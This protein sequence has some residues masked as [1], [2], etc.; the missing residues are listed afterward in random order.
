MKLRLGLVA[1]LLA[2]MPAVF[3]V[4]QE[5][6]RG[7]QKRR[8]D[9]VTSGYRKTWA[10]IV[11]VDYEGRQEDVKQDPAD[12]A[13]LPALRNAVNDATA[14]ADV[15]TTLYNYSREDGELQLLVEEEA[16]KSAIE[17]A[18]GRLC[19]PNQVTEEDSVLVFFS[20]HGVRLENARNRVA[21]L[22]YDVELSRGNPISGYLRLQQDLFEAL[23]NSPAKQKL[24]ILD[25]CYSG[26]IFNS[27]DFQPRSE[28]DDRSDPGL[29][30][31]KTFQAM[32]S[33]RATQVAS[34][35][36]K[37]H[38]PF[39]AA[40]L[41]G[42]R[43]LPAQDV[44][45]RRVWA[46]RLLAFIRPSFL[47]KS[48]KP[49]CRVLL[50]SDAHD[51]E[52]CFYPSRPDLFTEFRV[53]A[54]DQNLLKAMV[55]SRQG[56]WWF[57]EIP[58]FV[59]SVREQVIRVWEETHEKTR[60][61][62]AQFIDPI[63]LRDAARKA[64]DSETVHVDPRSRRH[65]ELLL[66]TSGTRK[67]NETLEIILKDLSTDAETLGPSDL[68]L[69]AIT[70]HALGNNEEAQQA[71]RDALKKYGQA[72]E[73][74]KR[75]SD[76]I[77]SALCHADYGEFLLMELDESKDAASQFRAADETIRRLA[78]ERKQQAEAIF[79]IFIL[80]READAWLRVNRWSDANERLL[81][82]RDLAMNFAA[83]DYLMAHVHRRRAWAHIIQWRIDDAACSFTASNDILSHLFRSG[84]AENETPMTDGV[85]LTSGC[86]KRQAFAIDAAFR[87]SDDIASKIAYLHNLHGLAMA[88]RFQGH[89]KSAAE[90]YRW[91]AGEVESTLAD[92]SQSSLDQ[93]TENQLVGRVINTVERLGD[94]NLFG[95][96]SVRDLKEAVDDYRRAR[97]RTHRITGHKR[98]RLHA[99]LLYKQALALAMPSTVQDTELAVDMS[100][101]ADTTYAEQEA[102]ATGLYW[103]VGKLTTKMVSLLHEESG[104][105]SQGEE[106]AIA[107]QLRE[108]IIECRD[109]VGQYP[110][111]DQLEWFL[112]A[113]KLLL[114]YGGEQDRLQLLEDADLLLSF[115][116]IALTPYRS[117]ASATRSESIS[118]LRPYYDSA[119][120]AKMRANP[121]HV[122]DLLEIQSEATTGTSYVKPESS[123]PIL[124]TYILDGGC[125]LLLDL[126]R[127]ESKCISLAEMYDVETIRSACY[128]SAEG[129]RLPLPRE[130]GDLLAKWR[131][132]N[133]ARE[134]VL[135]RV[136]WQDPVQRFDPAL[137]PRP[138]REE[139]VTVV[140][141]PV[142]GEFPFVLPASFTS[143]PIDEP[144]PAGPT[145]DRA[146]AKENDS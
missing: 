57:S 117:D 72:F 139:G 49:D 100:T 102:T 17:S 124:A 48:Q 67:F 79:R 76:Q 145:D 77:L 122:K 92:L 75:S 132:G 90:A 113:S 74:G 97:N 28:T 69:L 60:S 16:T 143:M 21:I 20:G 98:S 7:G 105:A 24:V 109:H 33:C 144:E 82:A 40:L 133:G 104:V 103:A 19:D 4:G 121:K 73:T 23:Q 126:P 138:A 130:A 71:Y 25:H 131:Q 93:N 13:T 112:F 137:V 116:R 91:L 99:T 5:L 53:R 15:L 2:G 128:S 50:G 56:N 32:A 81:A 22:A 59:P 85:A 8:A 66:K 51:G 38:S 10:L 84:L 1:C 63:A 70:N 141:K 142:I 9:S 54:A 6:T 64:L 55:S 146:A 18:L 3:A 29:Q 37:G 127:A 111:R 86:P 95:D 26:D 136:H 94:C 12:Q 108:A 110:H 114:E 39:T 11:G 58:W 43:R 41:D 88:L 61:S 83:R 42:L 30:A 44:H 34:D 52:F 106:A 115:C 120:R 123:A 119:M 14:L 45:N 135:I 46:N 96:P 47:D 27:R 125:Y 118:Y 140:A 68:H 78:T 134:P 89:T 87:S 65:F 101:R 62:V 107:E 31:S 35:G 129:K 36:P 80:C